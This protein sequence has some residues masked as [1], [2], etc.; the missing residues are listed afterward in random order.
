MAHSFIELCKPLCYDKAVVHE[1]DLHTLR[2]IKAGFPVL[3][4]RLYK[5]CNLGEFEFMCSVMSD[6]LLPPWTV[7]HKAPLSTGFFRQE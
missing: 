4:N 3:L 2:T 7:A 5:L 6:P 1:G